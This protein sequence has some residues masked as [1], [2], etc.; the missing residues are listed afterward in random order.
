M[1]GGPGTSALSSWRLS[2][3][4]G[5]WG[6]IPISAHVSCA[7]LPASFCPKASWPFST[8]R[9]CLC[10]C[11][12]TAPGN[13]QPPWL[14]PYLRTGHPPLHITEP[15]VRPALLLNRAL[16][17]C[18]LRRERR[19]DRP[20]APFP[21]E[22]LWYEVPL[23][24]AET[25]EPRRAPRAPTS[26]HE[27]P[28]LFCECGQLW[29]SLQGAFHVTASRRSPLHFNSQVKGNLIGRYAWSLGTG[30]IFIYPYFKKFKWNSCHC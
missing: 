18:D 15:P 19:R 13:P 10:C 1:T 27:R 20:A 17:I 12:L 7:V 3:P 21:P 26:L 6:I 4:G 24:N 16:F 30:L 8:M 22:W 28:F 29:D 5:V 9:C 23:W 14:Q 11:Q 2:L 25:P